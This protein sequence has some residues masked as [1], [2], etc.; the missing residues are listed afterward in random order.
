VTD[1][2]E[3]QRIADEIRAMNFEVPCG[4]TLMRRK[5]YRN[6]DERIW[7]VA[8]VS[9]GAQLYDDAP[10]FV[11]RPGWGE[12]ATNRTA[13][14]EQLARFYEVLHEGD[15]APPWDFISL[16]PRDQAAVV[17]NTV[18]PEEAARVNDEIRKGIDG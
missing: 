7:N 14:G 1:D 12:F 8:L 2:L 15:D 9:H 16:P 3:H 18:N 6:G 10:M 11:L 17:F 4:W 13:T 5:T